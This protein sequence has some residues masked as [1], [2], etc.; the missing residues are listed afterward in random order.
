MNSLQPSARRPSRLWRVLAVAA[1]VGLAGLGSARAAAYIKFD[2][3][4]GESQHKG[5]EKWTELT[6]FSGNVARAEDPATGTPVATLSV[7]VRKRIDKSSPLLMKRCGDGS[8]IPHANVIFTEGTGGVSYRVTFKEVLVS[9]FQMS[10]PGEDGLPVEQLTLN[11]TKIEWTHRE[12]DAR[13]GPLGGIAGLFDA[14]T[15][16]GA[17]KIRPA[18]RAEIGTG[19]NGRG[20]RVSCPVEEGRRYRI[21]ASSGLSGDW[22]PVLEFTAEA[23]GT[24]AQ[25]LNPGLLLPASFLKFEE[26]E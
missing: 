10:A 9:S 25:D 22:E 7:V 15:Q 17:E 1:L 21:L 23:D 24:F 6:S 8:V 19:P 3:I 2:G 13:G 16:T 11:F 20:L 18:F 26:V 14:S 12:L 5:H 4:D